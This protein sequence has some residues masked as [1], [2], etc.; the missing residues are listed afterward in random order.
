MANLV[1][2]LITTFQRPEL[3]N[4]GLYSLAQ[5]L[6]PFDFE[7]IVIN[8][9]IPDYTPRVCRRYQDRLQ[10]K[11]LFT[12]QR[13]LKGRMQWR[14]P[15]F[16]L[17]IGARQ[18]TGAILIIGGA[19]IFHLNATVAKLADPLIHN[20]K[21]LVIPEGRDDL[22]GSFLEQLINRGG[23]YD[24]QQFAAYPELCTLLPFFMAISKAEFMAIGG[25][26]EDFTGIAFDDCDL[27]SRLQKNGCRYCQTDGRIIH[28]FHPRLAYECFENAEWMY[29]K[30]L[31]YE[32]L[33]QVAR[34]CDRRW[35]VPEGEPYF[36]NKDDHA[37]QDSCV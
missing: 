19:E 4:W 25:Y 10:I 18:A 33:D 13:N 3:L 29:N 8:D 27:I 11:Y 16:A 34:N 28:L 37:C 35:G 9:G 22:D 20:P 23:Q 12:G 14:V 2:I 15:G 36:L 24:P 6:I 32:R 5:Q 21:L 1:S 7:T 31:Y 17:N 26:D 30:N